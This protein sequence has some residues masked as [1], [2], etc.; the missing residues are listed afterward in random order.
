MILV[1]KDGNFTLEWQK[2]KALYNLQ[3]ELLSAVYKRKRKGFDIEVKVSDKHHK[4]IAYF[5]DE[6]ETTVRLIKRGILKIEY[7]VV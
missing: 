7:D 2:A 1:N 4:N 6:G 3:G 5:K